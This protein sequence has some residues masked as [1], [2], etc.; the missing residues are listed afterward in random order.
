[1]ACILSKSER[2]ANS[3]LEKVIMFEI[4]PSLTVSYRSMLSAF[5][6][7]SD[8]KSLNFFIS[9]SRVVISIMTNRVEVGSWK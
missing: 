3:Y 5:V 9:Q 1:S 8:L 7:L 2:Y 6:N 4:H